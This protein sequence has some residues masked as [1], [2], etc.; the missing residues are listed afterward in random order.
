MGLLE[1]L[2]TPIGGIIQ[3]TL[4]N[5][6]GDRQQWRNAQT[7]T[8]TSFQHSLELQQY[9]NAHNFVERRED[10]ICSKYLWI[11]V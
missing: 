2:T 9:L 3:S 1:E 10:R 5:C 4:G 8:T 7:T 6:L 11:Q